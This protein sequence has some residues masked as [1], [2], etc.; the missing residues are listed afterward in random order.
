MQIIYRK[1]RS[2]VRMLTWGFVEPLRE[3]KRVKRSCTTRMISNDKK[4]AS[5]LKQQRNDKNNEHKCYVRDDASQGYGELSKGSVTKCL[6]LLASRELFRDDVL[7]AFVRFLDIGSGR[8]K[9]PIHAAFAYNVH[10]RGLEY[11]RVRYEESVQVRSVVPILNVTCYR[12]ILFYYAVCPLLYNL[13]YTDGQTYTTDGPF[14][15]CVDIFFF[16]RVDSRR[17]SRVLSGA[18]QKCCL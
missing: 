14:G 1:L 9:V 15:P 2:E 10:A 3:G 16:V 7:C 12:R 18:A 6:H 13:E 5:T 17:T 4:N 8:G 11:V